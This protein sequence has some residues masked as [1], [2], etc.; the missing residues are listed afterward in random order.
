MS[1]S[2]VPTVPDSQPGKPAIA[3]LGSD[4]PRG[5]A[6]LFALHVYTPRLSVRPKVDDWKPPPNRGIHF[7][8]RTW[9]R[10]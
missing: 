4:C 10:A 2:N 5:P 6:L 7:H 3:I 8:V 9:L 1:E